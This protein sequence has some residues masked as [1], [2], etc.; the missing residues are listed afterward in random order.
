MIE[1]NAALQENGFMIVNPIYSLDEIDS[2]LSVL[3][4]GSQ[5]KTDHSNPHKSPSVFAIRYLFQAIPALVPLVFNQNLKTIIQSQLGVDYFVCKS[6]YFDKPDTANWLVPYHQDLTIAVAK[7]VQADYFKNWTLKQNQY[8]VQPPQAILESNVTIRIHL[9]KTSKANGA[10]KVLN[11]SHR[12]GICRL[13]NVET[14]NHLETVCEVEQGG[15]ML[16]KP[17]LFHASDKTTNNERRRVIHLEFSKHTLP[18]GME[19]SEQLS[20]NVFSI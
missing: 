20:W 4:E 19:W 18:E 9:D 13:E 2:L 5:E 15:I 16:M 12:Q 1:L 7:K 6:I 10:L 17:L 8:G 11:Q 14:E 3:E